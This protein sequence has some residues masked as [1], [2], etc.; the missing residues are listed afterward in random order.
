[1]ITVNRFESCRAHHLV[2]V[3]YGRHG[4][5]EGLGFDTVTSC[6]FAQLWSPYQNP[7]VPNAHDEASP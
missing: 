1:V 4:T 2:S 5:A 7:V 3:A 6:Y